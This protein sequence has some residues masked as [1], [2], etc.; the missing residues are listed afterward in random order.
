MV[1]WLSKFLRSGSTGSGL[2]SDMATAR[3]E[4]ASGGRIGP[5]DF[6]HPPE[7]TPDYIA[8]TVEP[9]ESAWEHE[10]E[11]YRKKQQETGPPD[12]E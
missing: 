5:R 2:I 4:E 3:V 10:K 1:R 9:P 8:E 11:L 12:A 6:N 7:A